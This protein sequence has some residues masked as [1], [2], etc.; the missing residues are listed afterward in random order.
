LCLSI[1]E[2]PAA[3]H[4]CTFGVAGFTSGSVCV[5]PRLSTCIL[6]ALHAGDRAEAD[7]LREHFLP[8]E[9]LRDAWSPIRTMHEA[10]TLSG[11]AA[12]G[13]MLPLLSNLT[14]KEGFDLSALKAAARGLLAANAAAQSKI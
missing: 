3:S 14:A 9:D 1:G 12:C 5:A 4:F 6:A 11:V 13:P 7:R 10:V 8:L 2:R